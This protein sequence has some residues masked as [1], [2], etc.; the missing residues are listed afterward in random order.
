[1][2]SMP[3]TVK[4]LIPFVVIGGYLGSGKTTLLNRVLAN[5]RGMRAVVLVNDFGSVNIDADLIASQDATTINL[6]NG[7]ICCTIA[8]GFMETIWKI[9]DL[10]PAPDAV[11]V[12]ASGIANPARVA[13]YGYYPGFSYEGIVVLADAETIRERAAND[14]VGDSVMRQLRLG[15]LLVLTKTDLVDDTTVDE[16]EAWLREQVPG[17]KVIR[18]HAG[19]LP[20]V[21]LFG[22]TDAPA[23]AL[24]PA[25]GD[26]PGHI[27]HDSLTIAG[28][29]PLDRTALEAL[30]ASLPD[31]VMRAKGIIRLTDAPERATVFQQVGKRWE[32]DPG[33][34][35]TDGAPSRLVFIGLPGSIDRA[36]I[37]AA[38][39][40]MSPV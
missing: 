33:P 1:E 34:P 2:D 29:A 14:Y 13:A 32:L 7:C 16:T 37:L 28:S 27:A 40:G 11:I 21:A 6:A 3:E 39:P 30:A 20:L 22:L 31:G 8:S 35:W 24:A 18:S 9:Q 26:D 12:E 25:V 4:P 15:D 36:A 5:T 38:L 17:A 19:E 10:S 23:P